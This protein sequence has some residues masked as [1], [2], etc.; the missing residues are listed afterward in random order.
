MQEFSLLT[1]FPLLF[2]RIFL[3]SFSLGVVVPWW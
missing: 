3:F 2:N 1:L